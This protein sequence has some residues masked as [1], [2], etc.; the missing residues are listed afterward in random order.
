MPVDTSKLPYRHFLSGNCPFLH[1]F[2]TTT[3]KFYSAGHYRN[4]DD[5]AF[6]HVDKKDAFTKLMEDFD[7]ITQHQVAFLI[8]IFES[9]ELELLV[10][11]ATDELEL[12]KARRNPDFK[13]PSEN[14]QTAPAG[15]L[16]RS[17]YARRHH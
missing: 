6:A 5:C 12:H 10:N 17:A 4:G 2:G 11:E 15:P 14:K 7:P 16:S 1:D 9:G 3:C 8:D 13:V